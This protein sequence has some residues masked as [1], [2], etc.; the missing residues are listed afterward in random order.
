MRI[1]LAIATALSAALAQNPTPP[2][3]AATPPAAAP[4][5]APPSPR[6]RA[7]EVWLRKEVDWGKA[8]D[9]AITWLLRH[10]DEDGHWDVHGFMKH[11][12][13]DKQETGAGNPINDV[14]VTGL[15]L[16]ALTADGSTLDQGKYHAAIDKACNWLIKGQIENGMLCP[17]SS[18]SYIYSHCAATWALADAMRG[19][20][21]EDHMLALRRATHALIRHKN[22]GSA[23]RY[24]PASGD[25]DTSVTAWAAHALLAAQVAGVEVPE[26]P[27]QSALAW[28]DQV[29]DP[30][31]GQV[32]Y[33][34]MGEGCARRAGE[35]DRFPPEQTRVLT[36]EALSVRLALGMD[37]RMDK[38]AML[39]LAQVQ[40]LL[41]TSQPG[42]VDAQY[43]WYGAEVVQQANDIAKAWIEKG[44]ALETAKTW[45]EAAK[46][47]QKGLKDVVKAQLPAKAGAAAGAWDAADPWLE[48]GG[49][50]Y[51]TSVL[52]LALASPWRLAK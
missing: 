15:A 7:K 38:K 14:G 9:A 50:V 27:F 21:D 44:T 6:V 36:A 2:A 19:S 34:R 30:T 43:W 40:R 13:K 37:L 51:L 3:P 45:Q 49:R 1:C 10:Q 28:F 42:K 16:L 8:F 12:P 20:H 17:P 48:D 23:W 26:Q 4:K 5:A 22:A 11:D 29:T 32:S 46:N 39:G 33:A 24:Q 18:E 25:S 31:T 35:L 47:W 52:A 41:P